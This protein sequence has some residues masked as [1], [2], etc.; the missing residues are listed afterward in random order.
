MLKRK[1]LLILPVFLAACAPVLEAV[2]TQVPGEVPSIST[3]PAVDQTEATS[4]S[5]EEASAVPI[6]PT[7]QKNKRVEDPDD[8]VFSQLLPWDGI[9]PVYDPQ[10]VGVAD[11][12]L[13]DG[14]L[15]MGVALDGEAKA[16]PVSVLR[17]REMVDD[18]LAGWPILVSW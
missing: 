18:E 12:P 17:F 1:L 8:Y 14:E 7:P 10:F 3:V 11:S 9:R 5:S 2:D 13:Q 6:E 4:E 16:Y 15:V